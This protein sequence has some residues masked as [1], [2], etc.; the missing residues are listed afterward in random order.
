MIQYSPEYVFKDG[1]YPNVDAVKTNHPIPFP[2][3]ESDRYVYDKHFINQLTIDKEIVFY[4]E[5]G[6][7]AALKTE[8]T[9]GYE[10]K[11]RLHIMVGGKY[12]KRILSFS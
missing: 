11:G 4:D 1:I 3:I 10:L 7:R 9:W 5:A 6:V 2:R 12:W 8:D